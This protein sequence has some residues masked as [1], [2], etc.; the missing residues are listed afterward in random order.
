MFRKLILASA[1]AGALIGPAVGQAEGQR[2]V[3]ERSPSA[4]QKGFVRVHSSIIF[5]VPGS[6][7]EG[8]EAPALRDRAKRI[9]YEM[10]GKECD[11]LRDVLAKDRRLESITSNP[12]RQT[13][14]AAEGYNVQGSMSLQ[15]TLK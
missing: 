15:L 8:E 13:G 6:T 3:I 14:Q 5:F 4:R 2:I 11:V 7:G 12:H 10:A 9:V 1:A